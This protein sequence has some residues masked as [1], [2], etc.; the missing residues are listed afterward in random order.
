MLL[1]MADQAQ[2]HSL[3][4]LQQLELELLDIMQEAAEEHHLMEKQEGLEVLAVEAEEL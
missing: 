1:A 3:H 2:L 4:G